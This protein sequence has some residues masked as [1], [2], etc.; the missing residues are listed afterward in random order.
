MSDELDSAITSAVGGQ[1]LEEKAGAFFREFLQKAQYVGEVFSIAYE[2]ARVQ[3]HDHERR[4]VGGIPALSF[5]LASRVDP[6]DAAVNP[7]EEDSSAILLRVMD[8]AELPDSRQSESVRVET[9]RQVSGET[10]QHWDS[11]A[12][13]DA[14]TRVLLG[15]CGSALPDSG[16]F[17][18]G[19]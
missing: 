4:Q 7:V 13:M 19:V 16:D 17:L 14:D 5:L 15:V 12:A 8:A 10:G 1:S 3:I 9:A 2:T 11:D 6:A 18:F